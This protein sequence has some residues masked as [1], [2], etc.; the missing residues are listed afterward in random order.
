MVIHPP[1]AKMDF[2]PI[3]LMF[4]MLRDLANKNI[5]HS[6]KFELQR[7]ANNFLLYVSNFASDTLIQKELLVI[8]LNFYFNWAACIS[9]GPVYLQTKFHDRIWISVLW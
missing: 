3:G 6:V 8:H 2:T 7:A 9:V 1:V 5:Q 4:S